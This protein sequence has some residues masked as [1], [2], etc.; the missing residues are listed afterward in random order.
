MAMRIG[1]PEELLQ[2][3]WQERLHYFQAHTLAHPVLID[4]KDK[5]MAAIRESEPNSLVFVFGPS[6]VGKT[7]LR[8][9]TE[10][11]IVEELHSE[12]QKDRGR[13][14]V[15]AV[16]AIAPESGNFSWLDHFK[17]VLLAMDDPLVQYKRDAQTVLSV[18]RSK[19]N[20]SEY[21]HAVEQALKH[22]R[23]T[24]VMIDEAQHLSKMASGR[25]L[26][27]QLDVIKSI[28]NQTH[29][30]HV[31]IGTYDLLSFRN[32]NGQLSRRSVDVHFRRY[33]AE[34]R[35]D[36]QVFLNILCSFARHMPLRE[37]PDFAPCWEFLYERSV[38]C[39]GI[40]KQWLSRSL[41]S[42]LQRDE[43]TI[44]RRNL[45]SHA[46]SIGQ[47]ETLLTETLDGETRVE[48]TAEGKRRLLSRLGLGTEAGALSSNQEIRKVD[49]THKRRPGERHP[50]RDPIG[51]TMHAVSV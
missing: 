9:R 4:A 38:G 33:R 47:C 51:A 37:T 44:T 25:R 20:T 46:L 16:E 49:R 45:E 26:L 34:S 19:P 15:V 6:G 3:P 8:L 27:D 39:T 7:T 42:A 41:Y 28:A 11:L 17:R 30:V 31:L 36:R 43:P 18:S 21:R 24:A 2:K 22:R 23:P 10:Q 48:E 50:R 35:D 14:P 13:I 40:L 32:L 1:F 29:T 5:L 12:L